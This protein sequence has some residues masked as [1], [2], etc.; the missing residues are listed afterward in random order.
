MFTGIIKETG[1]IIKILDK[2][3]DRELKIHCAKI[4]ADLK[5]G[6]SVSVNG[7]CLTVTDINRE[8][9][10]CDVSFNTLANT[11]LK[12]IKPGEEVNLENSL[13]SSDRLGGHF[14]SGHVD[15]TV[16]ILEILKTGSSYTIKL[17]LPSSIRDFIVPK[18]SVAI[19]GIS[20]T[21]S[22][23]DDNSFGVVIIPYTFKYTN[24][25]QKKP[26]DM[27]NIEIDMLA[28]YVINFLKSGGKKDEDT[29]KIKDKILK[30]KL[31]EHGFTE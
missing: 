15:C 21:V 9:F 24:L 17:K 7:V 2:Q 1:K 6:D 14:V 27:V 13:T 18:G 4:L 29:N 22:E 31:K 23:T 12:Y 5:T 16:K 28:R 8:G 25:R 10:Y 11:S 3:K 30:E 26:G 20:L 19:E